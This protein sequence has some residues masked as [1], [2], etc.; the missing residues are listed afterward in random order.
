MRIKRFDKGTRQNILDWFSEKL[1]TFGGYSFEWIVN[2]IW[3]WTKYKSSFCGIRFRVSQAAVG[4]RLKSNSRGQNGEGVRS[5]PSSP[6]LPSSPSIQSFHHHQVKAIIELARPKWRKTE[7]LSSEFSVNFDTFHSQS[8]DIFLKKEN[9]SQKLS[10][11]KK[12]KRWHAHI[13]L[14]KLM[15]SI[16]YK[17]DTFADGIFPPKIASR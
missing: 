6:S 10:S 15:S 12:I 13:L 1:V 7:T 8:K 11:Q 4:L 9:F 5:S 17:E 3:P 14:I 2:M 16:V